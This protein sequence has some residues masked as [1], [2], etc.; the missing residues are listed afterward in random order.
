M[1]LKIRKK[2][3]FFPINLIKKETKGNKNKTYEIVE[4]KKKNLRQW[5]GRKNGNMR[6]KKQDK[7][8]QIAYLQEES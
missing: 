6:K 8:F 7:L 4:K 5:M 2:K 1:R 3:M